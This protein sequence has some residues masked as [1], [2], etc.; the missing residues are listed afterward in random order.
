MA[1]FQLVVKGL[2]ALFS[3]KD[4]LAVLNARVAD[5]ANV[6]TDLPADPVALMLAFE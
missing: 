1:A 2:H 6:R 5:P 3:P 4:D